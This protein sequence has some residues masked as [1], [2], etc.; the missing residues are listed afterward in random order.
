[1]RILNSKNIKFQGEIDTKIPSETFYSDL[2]FPLYFVKTAN[3]VVDTNTYPTC[4]NIN[5]KHRSL[6]LR[7]SLK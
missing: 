4:K 6:I 1:M 7:V 5:F 2:K 3:C